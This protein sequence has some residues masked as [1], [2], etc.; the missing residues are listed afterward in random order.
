MSLSINVVSTTCPYCGTGCGVKA[1]VSSRGGVD[2]RG[3]PEHP[4]NFGRLCVKGAALAQTLTLEGRLLHPRIAGKRATWSAAITRVAQR[5]RQTIEEHGPDSIAFY[6]S[7]QMLTEDYYVANKLMKGFIGSANID[8]NSRLCM[9]SSVAGHKRA[10][11]ADVVPN[12]YEDLEQADL[13]VLTGSNLAWCHPILFQRLEQAKARRPALRVVNI[14]PRRTATSEIAD[15]HLAL[16]PESDVAL[17]LGLLRFLDRTGKSDAA[18]LAKH[19]T[20]AEDALRAAEGWDIAAVAAATEIEPSTLA[21]FYELFASRDR[22]VTVYSQG[23]NQSSAGTDKV[24]AILNCHLLTGRIGKPG[25][26]PLSV[27]GQPNAMGGREVGG[28][29]NQLTCHMELENPQHSE[30][31]RDFWGFDKIATKPGL[32]AV[33]L[34]DAVGS[35]AIK[36]LWIIGTNPV[37]SLPEADRVRNALRACPFVVVSDAMEKTD[38]TALA[39]VLLPAA[40]WGEKDGV[41]TN[42]E[43]R[44]SRQRALRQP[45]GE[46]LPDWKIICRVAEAMGAKGFA[47]AG[48]ADIFREYAALSGHMNEGVRAFDISAHA[49]IDAEQYEELAPFQWPSRE[50]E[51]ETPAPKRFF[52]DGGFFT[53]DRRARLI[54]TPYRAPPIAPHAAPFTLNTGRVRDQWHTMTRTGVAPRLSQHVAEPFVEIHPADA[55]R[56]GLAPAALARIFN[57]RGSIVVRALATDHQKRGSLFSPIHWTDQNA[58]A[59]RVDTLVAGETD[60]ISGQPKSKSCNVA[61]EP[62]P[63][64]WFGFAAMRAKPEQIAAGYWALARTTFGWRVELADTIEPTDWDGFT[65][66]LLGAKTEADVSAVVLEDRGAG[67]RRAILYEAGRAIGLLFVSREPLADSRDFLC[68]EFEKAGAED[69]RALLAGRLPGAA[70]DGG[71]T[72]CA[73]HGVCAGQIRSAIAQHGLQSLEA[74][75]RVTKAGSGCGS[76]RPEIQQMLKHAVRA[77]EPAQQTRAPALAPG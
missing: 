65:R 47:Y 9:A 52:A 59:A 44:V 46:A 76:C 67:V 56:L 10:F 6:V 68:A 54:P 73:C 62:W 15:L 42:S 38:T 18:Y 11:G 53:P 22:V 5:F 77:H 45:A 3:D 64:A 7:G 55:E 2:V 28:L 49:N 29:A 31:V 35:G 23:V 32:K 41:V 4:A 33:E 43:R 75:A 37:D 16:K 40:P 24:N 8:T 27:T 69:A 51:T 36:A 50:G 71:R 20:G 17:F 63:A 12:V 26:G 39:H 21:Q 66:Q 14:D 25:A 13:V 72:I 30:I 60:P 57:E 19:A 74:V 70:S 1:L 61:I 58:S 48:P 34:F